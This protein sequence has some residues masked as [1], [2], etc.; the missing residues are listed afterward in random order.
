MTRK[1]TAAER[2]V[3]EQMLAM[4]E[5]G[6]DN[7]GQWHSIGTLEATKEAVRRPEKRGV[8]QANYLTDV[9]RLRAAEK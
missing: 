7:P 3:D 4:L 1:L 5:W 8:I 6:S 2:L 9:C